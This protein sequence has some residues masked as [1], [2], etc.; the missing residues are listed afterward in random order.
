MYTMSCGNYVT[1]CRGRCRIVNRMLLAVGHE[2]SNMKIHKTKEPHRIIE[3]YKMEIE[4]S[5]FAE[6][7]PMFLLTY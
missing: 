7:K 2:M 1:G 5:S 3:R 6:K 4:V